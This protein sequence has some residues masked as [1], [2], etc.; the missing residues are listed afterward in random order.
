MSAPRRWIAI[1]ITLLAANMIGVGV[2]IAASGDPSPRLIPDA[3]RKSLELDATMAALQASDELGWHAEAH[4]AAIDGQ[5][6]R[7]EVDLTDGAG[8]ALAGAQVEVGVRHASKATGAVAI[9]GEVRPGHYAGAI[10]TQ[11]HGLHAVEIKARR[12]GDHFAA[13][14]EVTLEPA[15]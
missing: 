8:A 11:G 5:H 10:D 2:L 9:L 14:R 3:Y 6:D 13:T 1:V 4:L 12:Q 15:P 7:I